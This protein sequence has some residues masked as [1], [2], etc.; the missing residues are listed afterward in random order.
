[1]GDIEHVPIIIVGGGP[2]GYTAAI[3]AARAALQPVCIEGYLSGG[4][5]VRSGE[6]HN[7]PG[8]PDGIAGSDLAERMRQQAVGCGA[9]VVTDDV[10]SVD[11]SAAPFTVETLERTYR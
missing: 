7:F 8:Y 2:A 9:R 11:L 5:I 3:Y 6:V 10:A 4:Q 1:M